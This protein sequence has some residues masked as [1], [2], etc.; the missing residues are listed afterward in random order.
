MQTLIEKILKTN[1]ATAYDITLKS[2]YGII[3][4]V[5]NGKITIKIPLPEGF[6]ESATKIYYVSDDG[7]ESEE[8]DVTYETIDNVRYIVFETSHFSTYVVAQTSNT[9]IIENP[10]TGDGIM[11]SVLL[12]GISVIGILG[13]GLFLT[14]KKKFN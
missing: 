11:N 3:R 7:T 4:E 8:F 10:K 6:D 14:K 2:A 9:P 12:G 1:K 5:H 13:C